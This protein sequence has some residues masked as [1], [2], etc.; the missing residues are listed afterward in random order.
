MFVSR[1]AAMS[2]I[3]VLGFLAVVMLVKFVVRVWIW[4]DLFVNSLT[5]VNKSGHDVSVFIV[6]TEDRAIDL[7]PLASGD[8]TQLNFD[9]TH[10]DG[11]LPFRLLSSGRVLEGNAGEFADGTSGWD[12]VVTL[13]P[14]DTY[15]STSDS[16]DVGAPIQ[17]VPVTVPSAIVTQGRR[18]HE[19]L[20]AHH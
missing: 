6:H 8:E 11:H 20:V 16:S 9:V 5:V 4:N 17:L 12:V 3:G 2:L 15:T 18:S 10:V 1:R 14:A 13:L 19:A 7:S